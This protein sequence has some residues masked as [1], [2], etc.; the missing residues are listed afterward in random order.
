VGLSSHHQARIPAG[1]A[2]GWDFAFLCVL[3][4]CLHAGYSE[5]GL[6]ACVGLR[7]FCGQIEVEE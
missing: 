3:V 4:G 1:A 5:N 6:L 7:N 2:K